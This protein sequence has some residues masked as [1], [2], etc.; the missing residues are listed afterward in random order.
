MLHRLVV[1]KDKP[2]ICA[3]CHFGR[4]H[5]R[6]WRIKG[7]HTNPIRSK[8]DVNPG[9]CVSTD[10]I[11]SAQPVL[12]PQTSG[13]LTSDLVWVINLF[14]DHTT[15][16]TYGRLMRSLYL[17]NTLGR[18]K[19]FEKLVRRSDNSVKRY[20]AENGSYT[21]NGFMASLDANNQTITFCGVGAHHQNGIVERRIWTVTKIART[22]IFHSQR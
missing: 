2:S 20:H 21:D 17:E 4:S 15:D 12:V 5:K 13:Y 6:P 1:L 22:I 9:Y 10:Q 3:S 16:Y 18:N 14:V 7:K 11:M 19:D 8:D